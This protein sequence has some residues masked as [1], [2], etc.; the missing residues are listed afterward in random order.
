MCDVGE[1]AAACIAVAEANGVSRVDWEAAKDG[2]TARMSDPAMEDVRQAFVR[3]YGPAM[4]K[5]R[6]GQEPIRLE[7]FVR[8][9]TESS[10]RK[11]PN[12]PSKLIDREVLLKENNLTGN[13]WNEC[14]YYWTPKVS[15]PNH[16]RFRDYQ[17]LLDQHIK[18]LSGRR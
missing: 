2:W 9:F 5:M 12:D 17:M 18:R 16:P 10:F 15:D 1:D 8:I 4:D 14:L 11:D 6:G 13:Q 3:I 7:D